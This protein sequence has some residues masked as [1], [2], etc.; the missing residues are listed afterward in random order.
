MNSNFRALFSSLFVAAAAVVA[1]SAVAAGKSD[2]HLDKAPIN[3]HDLPSLQRGAQAFVNNCLNCHSAQFMRWG[4]LTQIGLTEDQI[5][6]NLAFNPDAKMGDYMTTALD[7][8]DAKSWFGGVPPDLTLV[9]RSRGSDWLYTFLRS[10]YVDPSSPTGWNNEVFANVG[11]PHVL[12]DKQGAIEKVKVGERDNH[13]KK[14]DVYRM[15]Q[16][17]KGTMTPQEYDLYVADLVNYLTFMG[18][19]V[20]AKRHQLGVLVLLFLVVAFFAALLVKHE[21]WKDVK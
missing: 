18:E 16:T 15:E 2:V 9:A 17:R 14:E 3:L 12:H 19:P 5:K 21:Y 20:Q 8:N 1:T 4:H 13:G 11:M 6:A 10:Y 7:P